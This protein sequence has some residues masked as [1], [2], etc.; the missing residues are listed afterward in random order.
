[1]TPTLVARPVDG[2]PWLRVFRG[3][4]RSRLRLVCLP[5]AG[6]TAGFFQSWTARI[7]DSV[8]LLAV[9]YPGRQDRLAE[10]CVERMDVLADRVTEA[11][12]PYLDRPV[13]LFGHS[14]GAS[15]AYEVTLR[16]AERFGVAPVALFVS[17][18]GAPHVTRVDQDPDQLDDEEFLSRIGALGQVDPVVF[19]SAKLRELV[20]PA[21]RADLRLIHRHLPRTARRVAVP[22]VAYLG[23]ADPA[24]TPGQVAAWAELTT[25]GFRLRAFPG[26]HFYLVPAEAELVADL[27]AQLG[28]LTTPPA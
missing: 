18:H 20:L 7:P 4:L 22:I 28:D 15:V 8:D 6:G 1:M 10:P 14:M 5:H 21:L 9:R 27:T 26:D 23:T 16:L 25:G 12:V 3:G 17:G 13:A 2:D 11:L 24:C 19:R